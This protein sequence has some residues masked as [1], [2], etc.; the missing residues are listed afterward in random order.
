MTRSMEG[1]RVLDLTHVLAGPFCTYQLALMGADVIKIEPPDNPDCARGRGPDVNLNAA[2]IGITFQ[3]QSAGKRAMGLDLRSEA[4]CAILLELV[5]TADVLV[6]NYRSGAL[7]SLGLDANELCRRKPSLIHCSVTGFGQSGE[8]AATNAYDNVIQAASGLMSQNA[9]S[10]GVPKKTGASIVDYATGMNAAFAIASAL[11]QREREGTGQRIDCAMFDT[12]LILMAPEV[13]ASLYEGP[14]EKRPKEA[15]IDVYDASDGQIM[16]G[17]FNTR[18]NRRMWEA[19]GEPRFAA[20]EGWPQLWAN[21]EPM[22]ARLAEILAGRTAAE[23]EEFF[24]GIGVPAER[25]RGLSE[26]ARM[27]HIA[28]REFLQPLPARIE[29]ASP[30][31]VPVAGFR[32]SSDGPAIDRPPPYF[33]EHTDEILRELGYA[34]G[35]IEALR[36]EGVVA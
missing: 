23:W 4:G 5:D 13:A 9:G 17:A 32:Y 29:G 16:I 11:L 36:E 3:T 31:H 19:L 10:A 2:G 15:G 21:A 25:V 20:L 33:G 34:S 26:S 35:E 18:Q 8:R 30:V 27:P 1:I 24:H 22:R 6:E 14:K 7:A 12:A 28:E